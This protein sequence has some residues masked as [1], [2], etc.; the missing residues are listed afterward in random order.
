M[1]SINLFFCCFIPLLDCLKRNKT[2]HLAASPRTH[3]CCLQSAFKLTITTTKAMGE[4]NEPFV[5]TGTFSFLKTSK[6]QQHINKRSV[7]L[8]AGERNSIEFYHV[9]SDSLITSQNTDAQPTQVFTSFL[10]SHAGDSGLLCSIPIMRLLK[11][12]GCHK[13]SF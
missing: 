2:G 1:E 11:C 3:W 10:H 7:F 8:F 4:E 6:M 9:I 5:S 13:I 12:A